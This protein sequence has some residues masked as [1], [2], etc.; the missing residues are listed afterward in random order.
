MEVTTTRVSNTFTWTYDSVAPTMTIAST[1]A[2][3]TS[4]STTNDGTIALTFTAGDTTTDF[5][6]GDV[7]VTNGTLSDFAGNGANYTATFT[8]S[9]QGATTIA[10]AAAE[11]LQ[12]WGINNYTTPVS[13]TL[14]GHT[15]VKLLVYSI[16]SSTSGITSGSTTNNSSISMVFVT[17][18]TTTDFVVGDVT[19]TNGELSDFTSVSSTVYTATFT[20]SEDGA[21]TIKVLA[22]KFTDDGGNNNTAIGCTFTWTYDGTGPT[23]TIASTTAGV[24][25][26]STTND[27][28]IA[29]TFTAGESTTDFAAGDVTVTNGT[30]SDFAGSGTDYTATFTP[31]GQGA[32]TIA[33]AAET[34]QMHTQTTT[35]YL[36]PLHGHTTVSLQQ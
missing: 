19:V 4:G 26:G 28:T 12:I 10:V 36:T 1:T 23:M 17:S 21:T 18:D 31:S 6:A 8:P 2:G 20:P 27:G 16:Y 22:D 30:L 5:A 25:S 32:T 34:L 3:V 33:V 35:R 14:H 24:T 15:T 7:T 13:N 11:T 29:L 9:D